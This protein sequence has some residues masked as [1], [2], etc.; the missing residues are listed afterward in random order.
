MDLEGFA[1]RGLLREDPEIKS[2]LISLIREVK[3]IPEDKALL[4]A[5]AVLEE[6]AATLHPRGEVFRSGDMLL[7]YVVDQ[8]LR[9]YGDLIKPLGLLQVLAE[10]NAGQTGP[11]RVIS[12]YGSVH[13]GA[14]L[15]KV[16][17]FRNVSSARALPVHSMAGQEPRRQQSSSS[18]KWRTE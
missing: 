6:A 17:P 18:E 3:R 13:D 12:L 15:T 16:E 14:M 8:Q 1:K 5:Q 11:A 2:K 7:A 9:G 4:L 10:T